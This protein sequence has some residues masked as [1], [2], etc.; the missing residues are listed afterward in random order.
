MER[1]GTRAVLAAQLIASVTRGCAREAIS[2]PTAGRALPGRGVVTVG[3]ASRGRARSSAARV[4]VGQSH[5][6]RPG[7][8]G[9]RLIE[10]IDVTPPRKC[11][12][13]RHLRTTRDA[14]QARAGNPGYESGPSNFSS[15][16]D[17][18]ARGTV[19]RPKVGDCCV[20]G[21]Y[22]D[23][24]CPF[25]QDERDCPGTLPDRSRAADATESH[26]ACGFPPDAQDREC[27]PLI[28]VDLV[29]WLSRW[30]SMMLR[31]SSLAAAF[32]TLSAVRVDGASPFARFRF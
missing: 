18:P 17:C 22:G 29:G 16:Y 25:V 10:R 24:R 3:S 23:K 4:G 32:C 31:T 14:R 1:Q 6:Q 11:E 8:P 27:L 21:S 15:F 7:R 13:R 20:F 5:R 28:V 19:L 30:R 2:R 9:E 26:H 12:E